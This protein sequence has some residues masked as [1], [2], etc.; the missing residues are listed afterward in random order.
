[1]GDFIERG[2]HEEYVKR[3][4]DEHRRISK[5]IERVDKIMEQYHEIAMSVQKLA[6]NMENMLKELKSQGERIDDLESKDGEMWRKVSSHVI[7]TAVGAVV[8]YIFMKLGM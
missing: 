3:M 4:E 1:M 8:C 2:E 7:T 6:L 5:R